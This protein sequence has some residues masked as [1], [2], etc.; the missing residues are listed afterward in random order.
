MTAAEILEAIKALG[1]S[2]I[3][4]LA[5]KLTDLAG[6]GVFVCVTRDDMRERMSE[7]PDDYEGLED[8]SDEELDDAIRG[9]AQHDWSDHNAHATDQ[10]F[11]MLRQAKGIV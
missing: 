6:I 2:E 9:A 3:Q 8:A 1:P 4:D 11:D 7:D 10:A 5:W